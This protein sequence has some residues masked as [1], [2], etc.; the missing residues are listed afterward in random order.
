MH[1]AF[2]RSDMLLLVLAVFPETVVR[3][4]QLSGTDI[5]TQYPRR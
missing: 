1:Q 2:H 4:K 5:P 3:E